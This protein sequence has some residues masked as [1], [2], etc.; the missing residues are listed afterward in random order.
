[1]LHRD[2]SFIAA[3]S[4]VVSDSPPKK[5][6]QDVTCLSPPEEIK[7]NHLPMRILG[8]TN[9]SSR[10]QR[11]RRSSET[12]SCASNGRLRKWNRWKAWWSVARYTL[13]P[14]SRQREPS[15]LGWEISGMSLAFS[16][17][18]N[19]GAAYQSSLLEFLT[20]IA[21]LLNDRFT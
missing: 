7:E 17:D 5:W 1:M 21:K 16:Q 6:T 13:H 3:P 14:P 19:L 10:V 8:L 9:N 11:D 20:C 15:M 12:I 2:A 18:R 4:K